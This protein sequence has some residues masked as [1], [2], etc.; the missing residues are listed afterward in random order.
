MNQKHLIILGPTPEGMGGDCKY[1]IPYNIENGK[2]VIPIE[3]LLEKQYNLHML[4][5]E[6]VDTYMSL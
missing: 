1:T 5:K 4:D 3:Y 6:Q 2:I